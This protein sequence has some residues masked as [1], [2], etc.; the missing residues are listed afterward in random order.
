MEL[1]ERIEK[2]ALELKSELAKLTE[3]NKLNYRL[4]EKSP[5]YIELVLSDGSKAFVP[6]HLSKPEVIQPIKEVVDI[7]P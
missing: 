3:L 7:F 1:K 6:I 2:N 4:D 5:I